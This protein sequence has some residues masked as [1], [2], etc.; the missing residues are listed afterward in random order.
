MTVMSGDW[1]ADWQWRKTGIFRLNLSHYQLWNIEK[2]CTGLKVLVG[3]EIK[4]SYTQIDELT[5]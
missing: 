1:D 4:D 5:Q 2:V 3:I